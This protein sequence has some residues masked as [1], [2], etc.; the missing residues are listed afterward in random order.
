MK[1]G[2]LITLIPHRYT[3]NWISEHEG[4]EKEK[5]KST[6]LSRRHSVKQLGDSLLPEGVCPH[7]FAEQWNSWDIVSELDEEE[8]LDTIETQVIEWSQFHPRIVA[9]YQDEDRR[10]WLFMR[11]RKRGFGD[12][13]VNRVEIEAGNI[14]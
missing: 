14:L 4:L 6:S 11:G 3:L 12:P 5:I 8:L 13:T 7:A 1:E 10:T 2:V 9:I